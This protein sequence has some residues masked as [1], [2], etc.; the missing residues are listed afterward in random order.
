ME[1]FA[2]WENVPITSIFFWCATH[3]RTESAGPGEVQFFFFSLASISKCFLLFSTQTSLKWYIL[4]REC[5]RDATF[6]KGIGSNQ[7]LLKQTS[8][9]IHIPALV[10][11]L[12]SRCLWQNKIKLLKQWTLVWGFIHYQVAIYTN[13]QVT[14]PN[15][16]I[17]SS[18]S[19]VCLF[20][21]DTEVFF[22][23]NVWPV[24]WLYEKMVFY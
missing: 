14:Q 19:S 15:L 2:V 6:Y 24:N 21:E 5:Y 20:S 10:Y 4:I 8:P 9:S 7:R 13:D 22:F 18:I 16:L 3:L 23:F 1:A 17:Q 11:P 12:V